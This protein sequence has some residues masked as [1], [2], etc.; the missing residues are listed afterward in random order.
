MRGEH[1]GGA[2][3]ARVLDRWDHRAQPRVVR[4]RAA[5]ERRVEVGAHEDT[6]PGEIQLR[7]RQLRQDVKR[8]GDKPDQIAHP[9]R[10]A[11]L[12]V[13]PGE[14]L[15]EVALDQRRRRQIDDGRVRVA[16]E[17]GGHQLLV[18]RVEDPAEL[19]GRRLAERVVH[20][21]D[22]GGLLQLGD[23]I[24][25]RDVDGRHADRDAVELAL[26]LGQDETD[27]RRRAGRRR[28]HAHR[29]GARAAEVLVR[30]V[31]DGLVV[32]V[33][34]HRRGEAALDAELVV[35]HLRGRRQTVGR[36]RRVGDDPVLRG[37]VR[38]LVHAEHDR[39][40]GI[41]R[42]RGDDHLLGARLDVL[43]G[44][45]GVAEYAGRLDDDVDAELAPRE[46]RRVLERADPDLAPI[47]E[48]RLAFRHDFRLERAVHRIVLQEVGKGL[49]VSEVVDPD[50][51]DVLRLQ[52]GTEEHASDPT[53]SVD[54][55]S[56][57]HGELLVGT[58]GLQLCQII[59]LDARHGQLL[60][61]RRAT[62]RRRAARAHTRRAWRPS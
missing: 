62:P 54:A 1:D 27:G 6:P 24:D 43:G 10:I 3:F 34:V 42:R 51:F 57:T 50:D 20:G 46:R 41:L 59:R 60:A 9:R 33:R 22:G 31:V 56:N 18:R 52:R 16:V 61:P 13:V 21:R 4:D 23:E 45:G 36:A 55:D 17:I 12:V 53:E 29:G 44:G 7:D 8:L 37:I 40:V 49:R 38:L 39:R 35:E 58:V 14:H 2:G 5:V 32:R 15:D 11:P 30:K 47:H 28:D 26:E 25:D 48:D 19:S